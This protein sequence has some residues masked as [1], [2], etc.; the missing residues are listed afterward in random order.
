MPDT[1]WNYVDYMKI[2]NYKIIDL[3]NN[4]FENNGFE[5]TNSNSNQIID[6]LCNS[7]PYGIVEIRKQK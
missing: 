4:K 3:K 5:N 6:T 7:I 1:L 2:M